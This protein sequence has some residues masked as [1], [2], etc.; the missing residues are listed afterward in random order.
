[1]ISFFMVYYAP[2]LRPEGPR[3]WPDRGNA[4]GA[5]VFLG[6]FCTVHSVPTVD[7]VTTSTIVG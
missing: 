7:Y 4:G 1:M 3:R 2:R 6:K 5:L